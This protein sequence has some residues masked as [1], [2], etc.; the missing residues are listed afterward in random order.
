[1]HLVLL[2]KP[3]RQFRPPAWSICF[4]YLTCSLILSSLRLPWYNAQRLSFET[5]QQHSIQ[6]TKCHVVM[7]CN[8]AGKLGPWMR[9]IEHRP[10]LHVPPLGFIDLQHA[11]GKSFPREILWARMPCQVCMGKRPEVDRPLILACTL[12]QF[13]LNA[14]PNVLLDV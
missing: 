14:I 1:M 8:F 2:A 13:L 9:F 10:L 7:V 3:V 12:V 4:Y 5:K 11:L 6:Q